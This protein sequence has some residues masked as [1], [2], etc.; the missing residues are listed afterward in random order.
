MVSKGNI[1]LL[2]IFLKE[3]T[4]E[5][6]VLFIWKTAFETLVICEVERVFWEEIL[7]Y[8]R[9]DEKKI[10]CVWPS[11]AFTKL[12]IFVVYSPCP[13][14]GMRSHMQ[15]CGRVW[16]RIIRFYPVMYWDPLTNI[17][18]LCDTSTSYV[19]TYATENIRTNILKPTESMVCN[20][21]FCS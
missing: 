18:F 7:L 12:I 19:I 9:L 10:I 16:S 11:H 2:K 8:A 13:S 3:K 5:Y 4:T 14:T 17:L 20:E 21:R 15:A 6:S 1:K